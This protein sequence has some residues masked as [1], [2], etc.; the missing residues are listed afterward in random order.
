MR[1]SDERTKLLVA[2]RNQ[3]RAEIKGEFWLKVKNQSDSLE[4]VIKKRI[5]F[6]TLSILDSLPSAANASLG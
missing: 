4:Q 6:L 3:Q 5:N 2:D 1:K